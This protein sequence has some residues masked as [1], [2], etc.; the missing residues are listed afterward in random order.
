MED[1][2]VF[3]SLR[4]RKRL[5]FIGFSNFSTEFSKVLYRFGIAGR[6]INLHIFPI[7]RV[8][9]KVGQT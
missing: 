8:A 9:Q 4:R 3:H 6:E 1:E 7:V 2:K 5:E